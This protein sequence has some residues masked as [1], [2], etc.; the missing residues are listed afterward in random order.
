MEDRHVTLVDLNS[1]LGLKDMPPQSFFA[2]YDGHGGV[3]A[4]SYAQAQLHLHVTQ[5]PTFATDVGTQQKKIEERNK[6][7]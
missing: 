4:A 3:D 1:F 5:Q 7:R 2:I 6:I